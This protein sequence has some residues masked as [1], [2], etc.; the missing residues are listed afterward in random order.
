MDHFLCSALGG[1]RAWIKLSHQLPCP[2][3]GREEGRAR[4]SLLV[5]SCSQSV[6]RITAESGTKFYTF[7]VQMRMLRPQAGSNTIISLSSRARNTPTTF[8]NCFSS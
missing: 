6:P 4:T 5:A 1:P 8:L 3:C 7:L 2:F